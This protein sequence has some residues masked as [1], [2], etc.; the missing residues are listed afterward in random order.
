MEITI[1]ELL[2]GKATIIK[3]KEYYSTKG[4][5]EPFL[6]LMKPFTNDFRVKVQLPNQITFGSTQDIT[7]NRVLIEAVLPN[8]HTIDAHDEVIG[9]VYGLDVRK[10]VAKFYRGYLNQACTNLTVFNAKWITTQEIKPEE[11][12]KYNVKNLMEAGSDFATRLAALKT[13]NL[14][15]AQ[16]FEQLGKWVD[17]SLRKTHNNGVHDVKLAPKVAVDAYKSLFIDADSAHFIPANEEASM[18]DIYNAF[19]QI[20]TDDKKDIMNKFEKTIL[21]N[22][23]LEI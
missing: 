13:T 19:T 20:L 4:Y 14:T 7:Y 11:S 10:P 5:V 12:L 18:F 3:S 2:E 9:F 16:T 22:E 1:P 17:G 8:D 15:K 23:I 6:N 21:I